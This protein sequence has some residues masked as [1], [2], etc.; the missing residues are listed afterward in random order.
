MKLNYLLPETEYR[1]SFKANKT[2]NVTID[3]GGVL[4]STEIVEGMNS[5]VIATG[6]VVEHE[7]L[8]IHG[9]PDIKIQNVM[10]NDSV[11]ELKYFR[12]IDNTFDEISVKNIIPRNNLVYKHVENG[13]GHFATSMTKAIQRS[14]VA[15]IIG[16]VGSNPKNLPIGLNLYQYNSGATG[17]NLINLPYTEDNP[18]FNNGH[19]VQMYNAMFSFQVTEGQE[20]TLSFNY[21][22][23]HSNESSDALFIGVGYDDNGVWNAN[24][25]EHIFKYLSRNCNGT[26]LFNRTFTA[27]KNGTVYVFGALNAGVYYWNFQLELGD[28]FTGYEEYRE[29]VNNEFAYINP[30]ESG[31]FVLKLN[32]DR[33]Q[34]NMIGMTVGNL[35]ACEVGDIIQIDEIMILEGDVTDCYP[36][37]YKPSTDAY[38]IAEFKSYNNQYGFGKNK[39]I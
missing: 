6:D 38:Y 11:K 9:K 13:N 12:G 28:Q 25:T 8:K 5:I 3:L 22:N 17:K 37:K 7:F 27:P 23:T 26:G 1:V 31:R 36:T 21:N 10:V 30:D 18:R 39:L 29:Y 15:T 34:A 14:K 19:T 32:A 16:K 33:N 35:S 2:G 4:S 24:G 20:Y